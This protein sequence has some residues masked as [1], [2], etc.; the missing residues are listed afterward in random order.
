MAA[1]ISGQLL[2][3]GEILQ[4]Q[5]LRVSE[6]GGEYRD[7]AGKVWIINPTVSGVKREVQCLLKIGILAG[8]RSRIAELTSAA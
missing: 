1:L 7:E 3:E 5:T 6:C 8:D 4:S 2:S